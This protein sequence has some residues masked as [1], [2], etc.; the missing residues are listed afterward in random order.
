MEIGTL[1]VHEFQSEVLSEIRQL[2]INYI[3]N[4]PYVNV[5]DDFHN[6][7]LVVKNEVGT[8]LW[9]CDVL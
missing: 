4:Q 9:W 8:I 3:G 1:E 2:P 5:G 6:C 7:T